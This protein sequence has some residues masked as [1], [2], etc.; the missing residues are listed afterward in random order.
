MFETR[1]MCRECSGWACINLRNTLFENH[2]LKGDTDLEIFSA[3][4]SDEAKTGTYY[5]PTATESS[6]SKYSRDSKLAGEL[7][8]WTEQQLTEHGY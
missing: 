7:W 5:V 3:A 1:V 2:C 6:G 4:T 8:E